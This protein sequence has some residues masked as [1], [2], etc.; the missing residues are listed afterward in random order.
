MYLLQSHTGA[1]AFSKLL[2]YTHDDL[3]SLSLQKIFIVLFILS[4]LQND[5]SVSENKRQEKLTLKA[6]FAKY[7]VE[8]SSLVF[9]L[10]KFEYIK[11]WDHV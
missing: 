8:L 10:T 5:V 9:L 2:R 6:E 7:P 1:C 4:H 3:Y 11:F